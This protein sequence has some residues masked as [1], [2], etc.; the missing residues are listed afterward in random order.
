MFLVKM[1]EILGIWTGMAL[2]FIPFLRVFF[3]AAKE[4]RPYNGGHPV[5][6]WKDYQPVS[7]A[8]R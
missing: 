4:P 8:A 3:S 7:R 2:L 6:V 1:L 5:A